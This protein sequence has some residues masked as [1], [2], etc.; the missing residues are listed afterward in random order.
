MNI[1]T[2]YKHFILV[3]LQAPNE[4]LLMEFDGLVSSRIRSLVTSLDYTKKCGPVQIRDRS[5]RISDERLKPGQFGRAWCVGF[6]VNETAIA[7]VGTIQREMTTFAGQILASK[8]FTDLGEQQCKLNMIYT[9]RRK[10]KR[11]I[12]SRL[13]NIGTYGPSITNDQ[14][15][16]IVMDIVES[17]IVGVESERLLTA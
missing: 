12:G 3:I 17:V 10:L 16:A 5:I 14:I 1:F 9:T 2:S 13:S 15:D 7:S 4:K 11:Y 8:G 6:D